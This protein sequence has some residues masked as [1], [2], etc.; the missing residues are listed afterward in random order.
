MSCEGLIWLVN[1]TT[2][3]QTSTLFPL[4][5]VFASFDVLF[6]FCFNF[7]WESAQHKQ[8]FFLQTVSECTIWSESFQQLCLRMWLDDKLD[9]TTNMNHLYREGQSRQYFLE[10]FTLPQTHS[11]LTMCMCYLTHT[12]LLLLSFIYSCLNFVQYPKYLFIQSALYL[13]P[14]VFLE[15]VLLQDF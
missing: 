7:K 14:C 6:C 13:F 9:W 12:L 15:A 11:L 2:L 8:H 3:V 10:T 1:K 5:F 4:I